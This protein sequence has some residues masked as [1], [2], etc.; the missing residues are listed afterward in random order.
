MGV[1]VKRM[2]SPPYELSN[3]LFRGI[4]HS[5]VY[6]QLSGKAAGTI[7]GRFEDLYG[8]RCPGHE[9]LAKAEVEELRG[10]GLSRQKASYIIDLSQKCCSREVRLDDLGSMDED[11]VRAHITQVKGLGPWSADMIL[12]FSLGRPDILP[13]GDLGIRNGIKKLMGREEMLPEEM[14]T[15]AE[16]WR[17]YRT[18]ACWYLWQHWDE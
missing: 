16:P 3:D 6:Q 10:V 9:V 17:P 2:P 8:G 11:E 5:I 1:L 4:V 7:Y 15:A 12:M 13:L 18:A 14:T